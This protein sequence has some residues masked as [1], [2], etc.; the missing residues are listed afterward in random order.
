VEE[1]VREL[2]ICNAVAEQRY[3][4]IAKQSPSDRRSITERLVS[5]CNA[6]AKRL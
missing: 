3:K 1:G 2:T 4:L 5:D 6:I